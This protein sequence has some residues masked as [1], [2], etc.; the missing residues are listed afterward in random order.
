MTTTNGFKIPDQSAVDAVVSVSVDDHVMLITINR[1]DARNAVNM[2][3]CIGVGAALETAQN[4]PSVRAVV[5]TGAGDK[6]FCAGADLKAISRGEPVLPPGRESW[7]FAGW[8]GHPIDKPTICAVNGAALGG[9]TE[10]VLAADLTVA[11]ESAT[12]GLPEVKRG[13][14]AAAGGAFRLSQQIPPRIAMEL[15]MTGAAITASDAKSIGLV[16]RVVPDG[17]AVEGALALA[18]EIAENAPLAVQAS[19]RLAKGIQNGV[20]ESE[21]GAW[22]RSA[23]ESARVKASEDSR[24]GPRA[25]AEKRPPVWQAR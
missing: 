23:E 24:E 4:D 1:P 6:A 15:L 14:I 5:L 25:F 17:S 16:N 2:A 22:A 7:G 21:R 3:V 20:I 11:V 18:R 13:L 8:T 12:F 19:K 9:G 10:L